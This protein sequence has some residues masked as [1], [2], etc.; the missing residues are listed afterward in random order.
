LA[1][2]AALVVLLE[3]AATPASAGET[4]NPAPPPAAGDET[5]HA[6]QALRELDRFLDHH[7]LLEDDLRLVPARLTDAEYLQAHPELREFL[8]ANPGV[9]PALASEP[10][11]ILHHALMQQA[12]EPLRWSEIM[13]LDPVLDA[14]APLEH[15]LA[16]RPE[17]IHDDAFQR[18]NARLREV[19]TT[20]P[21]LGRAFLPPARRAP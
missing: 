2:V 18:A 17:L 21:A 19:L 12:S 7:P 14:A 4:A 5:S 11:H 10:R 16:R 13:Q 6:R 15:E 9:V 1:G 8:A 3:T 20:H